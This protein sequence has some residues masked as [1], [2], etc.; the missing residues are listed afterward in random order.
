[1]KR[2]LLFLLV[3]FLLTAWLRS[4][5]DS[6]ATAP[7]VPVFVMGTPAA[8]EPPAPPM[9]PV[10]PMSPAPAL[11][12]VDDL[13]VPIYPGT[14]VTE[15]SF[16][17]PTP[18]HETVTGEPETTRPQPA[19]ARPFGVQSLVGRLSADQQRA[20]A[21][22][23]KTLDHKVTEW[24]LPEVPTSWNPPTHLIDQVVKQVRIQPVAKPYGTLY[25][26]TLDADFAP[27]RRLPFF[28]AYQRDLVQHR[29]TVLGGVFAFVLICLAA[30]AGYIRA[31]EATKGYYTNGLRIAS[32]AGV[33]AA[34]VVLYQFLT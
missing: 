23:R 5:S 21:D 14:R 25:E 24:L 15:V 27:D 4:Q 19:A 11:E 7:P 30:L 17:P 22:V 1:M 10:P 31:D 33:G 13:P 20:Q 6:R 3:G 2:F 9:P 16:D 29:M 18:A 8:P 26:A 28:E 32:A 12:S 34:G